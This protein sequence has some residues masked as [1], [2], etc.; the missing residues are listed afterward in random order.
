MAKLI[1]IPLFVLF[2]TLVYFFF[3]VPILKG[4]VWATG[5][6]MVNSWAVDRLLLHKEL[7]KVAE[8]THGVHPKTR[9]FA[10]RAS[11]QQGIEAG[12]QAVPDLIADPEWEVRVEALNVAKARGITAAG[13][14]VVARLESDDYMGTVGARKRV[15]QGLLM[16]ALVATASPL[17]AD[18]LARMAIT[19]TMA[20]KV[21]KKARK[22]LWDL[23]PVPQAVEAYQE[24]LADPEGQRPTVQDLEACLRASAILDLPGTLG[25]L[26]EQA[27]SGGRE[28]QYA[29]IKALGDLGG[30]NAKMFLE[31]VANPPGW[32]RKTAHEERRQMLAKRALER[33]KRKASGQPDI[34]DEPEAKPAEGTGGGD[35]TPAE[36]SVEDLLAAYGSDADG[37][38]GGEKKPE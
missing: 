23:G 19:T 9:Y 3:E 29:A 12:L 24:I 34:P 8:L 15:E 33:I 5:D 20:D 37:D 36:P 13:P 1:T 17:S 22:A 38:G 16:E 25:R 2:C 10:L 18:G 14:V 27:R 6:G 31:T 32:K 11:H 28:L 26:T 35:G 4:M 7:E 21:R 30:E